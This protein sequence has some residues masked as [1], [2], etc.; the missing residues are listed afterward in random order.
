MPFSYIS[1]AKTFGTMTLSNGVKVHVRKLPVTKHHLAGNFDVFM[2]RI[3]NGKDYSQSKYLACISEILQELVTDEDNNKLDNPGLMANDVNAKD[4][5]IILSVA[6]GM[7]EEEVLA[8]MD[9]LLH[10]EQNPLRDSEDLRFG[11]EPESVDAKAGKVDN[12][13]K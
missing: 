13:K 4:V 8:L 1:P 9:K 2:K 5:N 12:V 6:N 3:A 11:E 7:P 10:P